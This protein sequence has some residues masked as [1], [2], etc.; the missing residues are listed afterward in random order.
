[1]GIV[2]WQ[3]EVVMCKP[4]SQGGR[5]CAYHLK[6]RLEET[7]NALRNASTLEEK[8]AATTAL[9]AAQENYSKSHA[10]VQ[11]ALR[12][13]SLSTADVVARVNHYIAGTRAPHKGVTLD[14]EG[15]RYT[16]TRAHV[17]GDHVALEITGKGSY[18]NYSGHLDEVF[19]SS[20]VGKQVTQVS[21]EELSKDYAR[22]FVS[23]DG[24]AGTGI[25]HTG[26]V[27]AVFS[28]SDLRGTA[29]S[30]VRFAS[31]NGGK[32]LECFDTFLPK[33]YAKAGFKTVAAIDFNRE[34]AP[35]GWDYEAMSSH[36]NGEPPIVFMMSEQ[37]YQKHESPEFQNFGSSEDA[38]DRA[39]EYANRKEDVPP[40]EEEETT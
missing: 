9:V 19:S 39:Y 22:V 38:W 3:K 16:V 29:T 36:H 27:A 21:P 15:G 34:F 37:E 20:P 33:V 13:P 17:A 11:E 4:K 28:R 6:K 1:M 40:P 26:E 23:K 24:L 2:E 31:E 12:D 18:T 32:H 25:K 8:T 10:G 7:Q 5:R 35:E 14:L 30:F